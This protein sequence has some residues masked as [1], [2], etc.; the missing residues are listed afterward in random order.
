MKSDRVGPELSQ[1][2]LAGAIPIYLGAPNIDD[3]VP[4]EKSLIKM[5]DFENGTALAEYI[6]SL[7]LNESEYNSYFAWKQ[8]GLFPSF[9]TH[10]E[11]C[12]H[13]AECRICHH[14]L[15]QQALATKK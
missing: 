8:N 5:T 9:V 7:I 10:L 1:A 14:V 3:F 13:L 2:W 15:E 4:G 12:A 11:N 6:Q